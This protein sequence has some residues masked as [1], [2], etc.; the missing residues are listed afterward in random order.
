MDERL[1]ALE[2]DY[3]VL[4]GEK[5]RTD[6]RLRNLEAENTRLQED[7]TASEARIVALETDYTKLK[8]DKT[9]TDDAYNMLRQE[10]NLLRQENA[11]VRQESASFRQENTSLRAENAIQRQRLHESAADRKHHESSEGGLSILGESMYSFDEDM[12][13]SHNE[14]VG[15]NVFSKALLDRLKRWTL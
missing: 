12:E 1:F 14:I 3:S 15:S 2:T 9:E 7:K 13:E 10:H 6:E 5:A 8:N 11:S 4:K